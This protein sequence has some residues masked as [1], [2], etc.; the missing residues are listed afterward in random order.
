MQVNSYFDGA[1]KS[2]AFENSE[3]SVTSGVMQPG[4]YEF[5]TSKDEK[6]VVTSGSLKVTLPGESESA[7]YSSGQVFHVK[8]NSSFKVE[9]LCAT[10]YLCFYS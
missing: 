1:V 4:Q 9:A 7:I 3:G 6:M 2:I 8:A 5:S 10:A